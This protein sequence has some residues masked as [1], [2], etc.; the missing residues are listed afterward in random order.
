MFLSASSLSLVYAAGDPV[1]DIVTSVNGEL[2]D[3]M[4][5]ER[6]VFVDGEELVSFE[7]VVHHP[8]WTIMTRG[9]WD[10]VTHNP[11]GYLDGRAAC[12]GVPM[13]GRV[14]RKKGSR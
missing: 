2:T 12:L 7:G 14:A 10:K 3:D 1:E 9:M 8:T 6:K 5:G 13:V 11:T 4:K